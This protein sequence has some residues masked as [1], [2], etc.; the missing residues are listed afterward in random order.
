MS[1]SLATCF[2]LLAERLQKMPIADLP[3][4][5]SSVES[6]T[7]AGRRSIWVKHD[8]VSNELYGGNK[9]RKLEY[10]LQRARDH[11]ARRIATFGAVGSNHALA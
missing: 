2:P 5:V 3:T 8:N 11:G 10:L 7:P 9:V 6:E 4:P 1:D